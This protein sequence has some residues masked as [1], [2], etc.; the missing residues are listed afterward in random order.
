M[1]ILTVGSTVGLLLGVAFSWGTSLLRPASILVEE[2]G[3]LT[4]GCA[5]IPGGTKS[6][7]MLRPSSPPPGGPRAV[8]MP[9]NRDFGRLILARRELTLLAFGDL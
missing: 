8:R 4:W 3:W 5:A 6:H 1:L 7:G 2:T 9:S